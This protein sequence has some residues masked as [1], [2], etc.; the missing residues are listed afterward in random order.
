MQQIFS[1]CARVY[2]TI[3]EKK[4]KNLSQKCHMIDAVNESTF[5]KIKWYSQSTILLIELQN[6]DF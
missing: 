2:F 6:I 5:V 4:E 1:T 3:C